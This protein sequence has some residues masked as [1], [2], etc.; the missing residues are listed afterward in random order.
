MV[1]VHSLLPLLE[2][3]VRLVG[4]GILLV[5]VCA[6]F[7]LHLWVHVHQFIT[8]AGPERVVVHLDVSCGVNS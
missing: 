1:R 4:V 6:S 7:S 8:S 3:D 2:C 5:I